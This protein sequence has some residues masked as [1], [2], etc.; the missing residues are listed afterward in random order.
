[1]LSFGGFFKPFVAAICPGRN[2]DA[3]AEE[4]HPQ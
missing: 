3:K 4:S 1:M 2:V